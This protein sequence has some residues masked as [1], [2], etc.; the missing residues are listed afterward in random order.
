LDGAD[1]DL[2]RG[3]VA[4]I[5]LLLT[6]LG[7]RGSV[8]NKR[9]E[10]GDA[11]GWEGKIRSFLLVFE[12][13][14]LSLVVGSVSTIL[15]LMHSAFAH[16]DILELAVELVVDAEREERIEAE[17]ELLFDEFKEE[18]EGDLI[19]LSKNPIL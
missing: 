18:I 4:A 1:I 10:L 7:G 9:R 19:S 2:G 12:G 6:G 17:S 5:L 11:F 13:D 15:S 14:L 16:F 8:G 3:T